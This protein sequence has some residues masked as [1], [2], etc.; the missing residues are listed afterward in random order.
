MV[1]FSV[2]DSILDAAFVVDQDGKVVYCN[3]AGATFCATSVRRVVGKALLSDLVSIEEPGIFPF[4][5][6][7]KGR[8][9]ATPFIE[10]G[11]TVTRDSR[12]GKVQLAIRPLGQ[13]HWFFFM[14]DVSLEEALHS[15]YRSELAQKEDYARN[16]EKLVEA[17]T[18]QLN[19]VN[20]TLNAILNSLGQGFFTFNQDGDCGDVFTR[21][22]EDILEGTPKGRKVWDVLAVSRAER[23][24]F[25][26]WSESLF[27][28]YLPFE[29]MKSLG[30]G[31]FPH[32][33]GR[34]VVLDF[35]PIR[36]EENKITD[37]VVVATDK[38]TEHE[39]QVALESERQFAGMI[40]RYTKNKDQF[41][42]FL[43]TVGP[44]VARLKSMV[45]AGM[46][47]AEIGECFRVL[48]T[49]EGEAGTFCLRELRDSARASQHVLE[50]H[51]GAT[52]MPEAAR[53]ELLASLTNLEERFQKFLEESRDLF[54]LPRGQVGRTVELSVDSLNEFLGELRR[55]PQHDSLAR[56]YQDL[57]LKIPIEDRLKY[58]DGLV[59]SVAERLGKKVQPLAIE[60]GDV[61][62][63][64]EPYQNFFS[65]LVHAFRNAVDHGLESPEERDW[66]GK[67]HAG[68]IE[69]HVSRQPGE[70]RLVVAD[71]GK[72]IDP[73]VIR[74]KL[75]GKFPSQDFSLQSDEDIIQ[76]VCRPGFSSRDSI[77]EFSG[78]GVG[79]DALREEVLRLGGAIHIQSK[80]GEGTRIEITL[81]E[82]EMEAAALRSA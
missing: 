62:I 35:F 68:R 60:G 71:D 11:F 61:R 39:A 54:R 66:A 37:V 43:A 32:S 2:L 9:Q 13:E 16:L 27:N 59:Q 72:G 82:I 33:R 48:H 81:P 12:S 46:G 80:V 29:D 38:T 74:E 28:E 24:Q 18:A 58:F 1:D 19:A 78:R 21:A 34:H 10:T 77:G 67:P 25:L 3:D 56:R 49:L 52:T 7:S 44:S 15:K 65:S 22:C 73:A 47:G 23:E 8:A 70:I 26:R 79:L 53:L 50:V 4:N 40:V 69:V 63:F 14:R 75:K 64:P 55:S 30:P 5:E 76:N 36:R 6:D 42:S 41:L 31:L 45:S 17:R 20:Q 51:K 57:F